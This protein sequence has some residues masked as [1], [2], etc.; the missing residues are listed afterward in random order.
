MKTRIST[1]CPP[2]TF[3]SHRNTDL[4]FADYTDFDKEHGIVPNRGAM[5][6]NTKPAEVSCVYLFNRSSILTCF[7]RFP[8]FAF[9][10][11][12]GKHHYQCE[13]SIFAG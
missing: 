4:Y 7:D 10:Y 9:P 5:F 13:C 6:S 3:T 8:D 1:L 2:H 12:A 11:G